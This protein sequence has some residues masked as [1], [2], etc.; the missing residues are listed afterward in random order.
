MI[1]RLYEPKN[2]PK[3]IDYARRWHAKSVLAGI[4]IDV[5]RASALLR[6]SFMSPDGAVWASYKDG[7]V[8]GLLIGAVLDWPY[9]EGRYV[10]DLVFIADTDGKALYKAL[11]QWGAAHG[12]TSIQMGVSSGLP[13]AGKFYET[14]GLKNVGGIYFGEV[15]S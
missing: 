12:A 7:K 13:Q 2:I 5:G 4:P 14:M 11:V 10:T 8:R 1:R 6:G 15:T 9:L 3:L